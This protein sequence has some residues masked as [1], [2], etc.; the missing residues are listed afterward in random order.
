MQRLL[1]AAALLRPLQ[2]RSHMRLAVL[3]RASKKKANKFSATAVVLDPAAYQWFLNRSRRLWQLSHNHRHISHAG[4]DIQDGA[5]SWRRAGT[6]QSHHL[7]GG[8]S[9]H[10]PACLLLA[11]ISASSTSHA[12]LSASI[13]PFSHGAGP[14]H[15][16]IFIL[17]FLS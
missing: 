13:P 5:T 9:P 14:F 10:P 16:F 2:A 15:M 11:T 3:V 8:H 1:R 7:Q 12:C 6:D 17:A 4:I